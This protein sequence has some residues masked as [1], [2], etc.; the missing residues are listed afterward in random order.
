M[1]MRE[2]ILGRNEWEIFEISRPFINSVI[3]V[4]NREGFATNF[5]VGSGPSPDAIAGPDSTALTVGTSATFT[6]GSKTVVGVGTSFDTELV[7][8]D[9][10]AWDANGVIGVVES[11]DS[12]LVLQLVNEWVGE[13]KVATAAYK[14][15]PV[16]RPLAAGAC[17]KVDLPVGGNLHRLY[18]KIQSTNASLKIGYES[19]HGE[20]GAVRYSTTE[21]QL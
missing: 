11:I 5:R 18:H 10:I 14:V 4:H 13:T 6:K 2:R 16:D 9:V 19:P 17:V 1:A 12:A 7:V 8:G 20:F 21:Q 15:T 3:W